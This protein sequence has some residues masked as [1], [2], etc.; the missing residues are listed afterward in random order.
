MCR[1]HDKVI[2]IVPIFSSILSPTEATKAFDK[3]D[4]EQ[5]TVRG[6]AI[7][8]GGKFVDSFLKGTYLPLN[9]QNLWLLKW[10]QLIRFPPVFGFLQ[11][12]FQIHNEQI[13]DVVR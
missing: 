12:Q 13:I 1:N 2:A 4:V 7:K 3:W 6:M 10:L 11:A 9:L 5:V 8:Y